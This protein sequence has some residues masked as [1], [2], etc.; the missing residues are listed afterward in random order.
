M[1]AAWA[2]WVQ[3]LLGLAKAVL[4]VPVRCGAGGLDSLPR[5]PGLFR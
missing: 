2:A 4:Y 5:L 1:R 3:G